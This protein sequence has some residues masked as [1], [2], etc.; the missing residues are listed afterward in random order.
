MLCN[1]VVV[2]NVYVLRMSII[3]AFGCLRKKSNMNFNRNK[4][5]Q[6]IKK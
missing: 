3:F 6:S 2:K 1:G 4:K 5:Y